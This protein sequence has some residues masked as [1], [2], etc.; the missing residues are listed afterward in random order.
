MNQKE[1]GKG[2][3][4]RRDLDEDV[5]ALALGLEGE[6]VDEVVAKRDDVKTVILYKK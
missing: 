1:G 6:E 3:K 2:G 5:E 4:G